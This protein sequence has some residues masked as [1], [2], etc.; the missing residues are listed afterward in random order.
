MSDYKKFIQNCLEES[1][2]I[3]TDTFGK[4]TYT[5]KEGGHNQVLTEADLAIGRLIIEKIEQKFPNFNIIDEETG[6]IDNHSAFTWVIDPIDG[7]SNF[8]AGVPTYGI[9]LGLLHNDKI[10]A[11]GVALPATNEI[12][13][14]EKGK[15]AFLNGKQIFVTKETELINCL[16]AYHIDGHPEEP[17]RTKKESVMFGEIILHARNMRNSGCEPYDGLFVA[18][19]K[20]GAL[21]NQSMKIW[22]VVAPQIIIEEAGSVYTDFWGNQ[23]NYTNPLSKAKQNFTCCAASPV[24]HKQLQAIIHKSY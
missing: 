4:V 20:Y 19:G 11:G 5:L 6:V 23:I 7:T 3:A 8:A 9:M 10:I 18:N 13:I 21:V 2:K 12:C 15:G 1:S 22:D 16:V 17:E 14:A 24:L